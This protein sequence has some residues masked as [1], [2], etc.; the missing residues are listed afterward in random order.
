VVSRKAKILLNLLRSLPVK[1]TGDRSVERKRHILERTLSI[2]KVPKAITVE[3]TEINNL[4]AEWLYPT[5]I[6]YMKSEYTILYLHGGAYVIGSPK[7]HRAF[8][9]RFSLITETQVLLLDYRLAPE[10]PF[11][12]ALEDATK[13]YLNLIGDLELNPKKVIIMGDSAGGGLTLSTMLNLKSLRKTLPRAGICISPWTDLTLSGESVLTKED[14]DPQLSK[15]NLEFAAEMYLQ[16]QNP[17]NPLVSPLFGDLRGLPSIFI[18]VGT[19]EILLDDS[20]RFAKK[21]LEQGV[22][23][24]LDIWEEMTHCFTLF[25]KMLP[26]SRLALQRIRDFLNNL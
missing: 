17:R 12:A 19:S 2:L 15:K 14:E 10:F 25:G 21:A 1:S 23:V 3:K 11:P 18:Q 9:G 20:I 16:G 22:N 26:E 24:E 4:N 6:G 5:K 13:A 8:A 7:T